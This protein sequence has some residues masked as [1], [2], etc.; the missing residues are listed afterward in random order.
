[1]CQHHAPAVFLLKNTQTVHVADNSVHSPATMTLMHM[2]IMAYEQ[3]AHT[4]TY[5]K[6]TTHAHAGTHNGKRH[7]D[8]RHIAIRQH[9]AKTRTA[10]RTTTTHKPPTT[11]T[12]SHL[13]DAHPTN[14]LIQPT[15]QHSN[16]AH[17]T[18]KSL[19]HT[20]AFAMATS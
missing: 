12:T 17:I 16:G 5:S 8:G 2:R 19:I 13:A 6:Q 15:I 14:H 18:V 9:A 10:S 4:Y 11:T 3:H 7:V 1:M 20:S